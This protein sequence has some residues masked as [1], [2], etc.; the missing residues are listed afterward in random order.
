MV[1]SRKTDRTGRS[2]AV[3]VMAL[4]GM[5]LLVS[6]ILY[7]YNVGDQVNKR[8]SLQN[9]ADSA[10]IS[11][12]GWMAR[13]ANTTAM[14]NVAI[15]RMLGILPTMDS[16]PL[17]SKMALEEVRDWEVGLSDQIDALDS[18]AFKKSE[19]GKAVKD[20]LR[21]TLEGMKKLR[22]RM[23][24]QGDILDP[25]SDALPLKPQNDE[26]DME[27][28][29]HWNV[30]GESGDPPHGMLWKA[31][32]ALDQYSVATM[33]SSGVLAQANA[34]RFGEENEA[35]TAI[36]I[37]VIPEI[38]NYRGTLDDFQP[39]LEGRI[40]VTG[41][42]GKPTSGTMVETGSNGGAIPDYVYY[43]RLGP[44]AR[45]LPRDP[46]RRE[47]RIATAWKWV[48][49]ST[50]SRNS[51]QARGG[52]GGLPGRGQSAR[53]GSRSG[54]GVGH[55]YYR[56]TAWEVYGYSTRGPYWWGMREV[57]RYARGWHGYDDYDDDP[58]SRDHGE[59]PDTYFYEYM[60]RVSKIKLGYMF[61]ASAATQAE[62]DIHYP[63]WETNY[64]TALELIEEEE[65]EVWPEETIL[66]YFDI[67]SSVPI[68][69]ADFMKPGTYKSNGSLALAAHHRGWKDPAKFRPDAKRVAEGD[70]EDLY[71]W[72]SRD[73]YEITEYPEIGIRRKEIQ[74]GVDANG[75]PKMVPVF[76]PVYM[77]EV[78]MFG[79]ADFGGKIPVSNP[80]NWNGNS[81]LEELPSPLL[82]DTE[83]G[84]YDPEN[85]DVDEGVRREYFAYLAIAKIT[86]KAPV[87][88]KKFKSGMPEDIENAI[89][90]LSQ[91][92]VFNN[93]SWGLWTQDW[94]V[95][96]TAL[97][98][99]APNE[100]ASQDETQLDWVSRVEQDINDNKTELT[101]STV[102][103][104]DL[105]DAFDFLEALAGSNLASKFL[106]H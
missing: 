92:K 7:V 13:S 31:A 22:D 96:L 46:W 53:R 62:I 39:P 93:K 18:D 67:A 61:P 64:D 21:E 66:Y 100:Q 105:Q 99:L 65:D 77:L 63:Q 57:H 55:G 14:N 49:G 38:P 3:L 69:S 17:C 54:R 48:P 104:T 81:D 56:A 24:D 32:V 74:D 50:P 51:I 59:L 34:R 52:R 36:L 70:V 73:E 97:K 35:E 10:A 85:H 8:L 95:Q 45:L 47:E 12:A 5:T 88:A 33:D 78:C 87:W 43:H 79:A 9:A 6:M 94:Q 83:N 60:D 91:A 41:K 84:D 103:S 4:L 20:A 76:Q 37:P 44:W 16:F 75:N 106:T 27:K 40:T 1:Y 15:S 68:D 101:R 90:T 89:Q 19:T 25:F 23:E 58:N 2:G 30:P 72:E 102:K 29:T 86:A 42:D 26:F 82:I 71:L 28:A 11:G 80:C 98:Q